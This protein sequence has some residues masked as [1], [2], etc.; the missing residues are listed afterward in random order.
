MAPLP[1]MRQRILDAA[2][3]I[4]VNDGVAAA[5]PRAIASRAQIDQLEL[6]EQYAS[7]EELLVDLL[8]R[9]YRGLRRDIAEDVARDPA[10]GLTSRIFH[11]ALSATYERPL[12]RAL[13]VMDPDGLGTI[14]RAIQGTEFA[15]RLQADEQFLQALQ[16]AGMIRPD[17]DIRALGAILSAFMFGSALTAS[18]DV[19]DTTIAGLVMLLERAVDADV[20][21]TEAGKQAL[22]ELLSRDPL[23]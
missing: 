13:Y 10:G 18:S 3:D 6:D 14:L 19:I 12:A 9:E 17:V 23:D 4:I 7:H 2:C 1:T 20:T 5:T 15:P 16:E 11:Y 22:Y 8:L 21:D